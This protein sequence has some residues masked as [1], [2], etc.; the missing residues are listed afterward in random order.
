M[1]AGGAVVW[2]TPMMHSVASA[3]ASASCGNTPRTLNW[4]TIPLGHFTS[5][6]VAGTTISVS[7]VASNTV[8]PASNQDV[9]SG[10]SGG[11]N[12]NHLHFQMVPN[13][14]AQQV[15]TFTFSR[16]VT[17]LQI[18]V[19]DVDALNNAGGLN[20]LDQIIV[21][22]SP[23]TSVIPAGST[24]TGTGTAGNPYQND[25][26]EATNSDDGNLLLRAAGPITTFQFTYR[27]GRTGTFAQWI[28]IG[29]IT[30][31]C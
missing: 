28:D 15:I 24:V 27:N 25:N 30:F 17:S 20:Y 23:H 6:T 11:V 22:T 10:E 2:A 14:N 29:N 26:F 8:P 18:P 21:N 7:S 31:N 13:A 9:E 3:Q 19:Y 16:A 1:A 5:T 12:A 4:G